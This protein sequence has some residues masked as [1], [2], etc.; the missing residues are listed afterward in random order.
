M[1][2]PSKLPP[3]QS[4]RTQVVV[5]AGFKEAC[6]KRL[7]SKS[8]SSQG[9]LVASTHKG[10]D[11]ALPVRKLRER[12]GGGEHGEVYLPVLVGRHQFIHPFYNGDNFDHFRKVTNDT[13]I[14]R[15]KEKTITEFRFMGEPVSSGT[16]L[17]LTWSFTDRI[18]S[19]SPEPNRFSPKLC[20]PMLTLR[21]WIQQTP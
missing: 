4:I 20:I 9:Q 13:S 12:R 5:V 21:P 17:R 11:D 6:L 1:D 18:S 14:L 10:R 3:S 7:S 2:S 19:S 8:G 16:K 15:R